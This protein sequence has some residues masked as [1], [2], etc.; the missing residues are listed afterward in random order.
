MSLKTDVGE[1]MRLSRHGHDGYFSSP[2]K[3]SMVS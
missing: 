3:L 1:Q 2:S